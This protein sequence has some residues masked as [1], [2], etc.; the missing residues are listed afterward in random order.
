MRT[1]LEYY[2]LGLVF[3][4]S[5]CHEALRYSQVPTPI[6]LSEEVIR[7]YLAGR[8]SENETFIYSID[9]CSDDPTRIL[10]IRSDPILAP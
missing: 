4:P 3:D 8:S 10:D 5:E 9:V 6:L 2:D 1:Q 7:I